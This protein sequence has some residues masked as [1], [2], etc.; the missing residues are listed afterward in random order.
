VTDGEP[1]EVSIRVVR[2]AEGLWE[3]FW[4]KDDAEYT[5]E[6]TVYDDVHS[7][8]A[9]MGMFCRFTATRSSAF[10]FD[11]ITVSGEANLDVPAQPQYKDVIVTEIFADPSP[12]VGL[13]AVEFV[14]LYNRSDKTL[15]LSG[16][17]LSDGS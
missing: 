10:Y 6:G 1:V 4:S 14:E 16:W 13:P 11:D 5:S 17:T 3:L 7:T 9:Y 15:K 8:S 2:D 12:V